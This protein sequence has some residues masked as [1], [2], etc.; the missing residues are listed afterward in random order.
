MKKYFIC[1]ANSKKYGERCIA[2]IEVLK[3]ENGYTIVRQDNKPKWIRPVT[4]EKHGA[5]PA[6]LVNNISLLDIIEIDETEEV[7][8]GYQSENVRFKESSLSVVD[9]FRPSP[10]DLAAL[11]D[12]DQPY[13]FGRKGKALSLDAIDFLEQSLTFIKATSSEIYIKKD[14][15]GREQYRL[16]FIFNM[17]DYDLPITDVTFLEKCKNNDCASINQDMKDGVYLTIS[18]GVEFEGWYY[19]LVAGVVCNV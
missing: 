1:L 3:S 14:P 18:V 7:P 2:G 4:Q 17:Q 12:N 9:Q 19:K 6:S 8:D 16:K 10:G 11:I 5:V 15:D 13:L